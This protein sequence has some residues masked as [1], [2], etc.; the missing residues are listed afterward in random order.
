VNPALLS[1]LS[2][3]GG[4]GDG[5]RPKPRDY[6]KCARPD[7]NR[8]DRC[9]IC[10]LDLQPEQP[11]T[12]GIR[13]GFEDCPYFHPLE[14]VAGEIIE[15]AQPAGEG[16]DATPARANIILRDPDSGDRWAIQ[17][18]PAGFPIQWWT[19]RVKG[20]SS[21][22]QFAQLTIAVEDRAALAVLGAKMRET[23]EGGSS[24]VDQEPT[25]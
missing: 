14:I 15:D 24:Q 5:L 13:P 18:D 11:I 25:P 4:L 3:S 17:A 6:C 20:G 8:R 22:H 10:Y 7:P 23:A 2:L 1:L 9:R 12:M 16:V 21:D 19:M